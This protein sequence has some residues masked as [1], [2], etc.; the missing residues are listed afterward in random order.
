MIDGPAAARVVFLLLPTRLEISPPGSVSAKTAARIAASTASP[1][2]SRISGPTLGRSA[3]G[4]GTTI[5]CAPDVAVS[6]ERQA[7]SSAQSS[8]IEPKRS[9]A[10]FAIAR[11]ITASR[12][13][14]TSGRRSRTL[15]GGSLMCRNA[16][17]TK[18]SP[19]NGTSPVSSS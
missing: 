15:G 17:A 12:R 7:V 10:S 16:T 1:P 9:R 4:R 3:G 19:G 8:S 13:G 5:V 18:L 2:S 11:L 14:E 6:G